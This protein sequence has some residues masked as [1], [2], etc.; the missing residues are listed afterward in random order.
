MAKKTN[1]PQQIPATNKGAQRP[2][3]GPA[4]VK[5]VATSGVEVTRG[6]SFLMTNLLLMAA[7]LIA[8]VAFL[9]PSLQNQFTNWDDP[10]YVL[11][12]PIIKDLSEGGLGRIF[13][14]SVMGNYHPLTML[15]YA[16]DYSSANL[17]PFHYHLQS[18]LFHLGTTLLV[19]V[20][21]LMLTKRPVAAVI[22]AL[23]FGIHPM[24]VE[25]VAW[26]A[27]RKDVVYG[28]FYMAACVA[29]LRYHK[30][31]AGNRILWYAGVLLLFVCSLLAKPVAVILPVTLLLI[32]LFQGRFAYLT[33]GTGENR[34]VLFRTLIEKIPFF[35]ISLGFG[36]RSVMYQKQFG[37]L[38]TQGEKFNFFERIGLGGYALVSYLWKA[39]VPVKLL[40]FYP[41]P[42]KEHG[43]LEAV[44]Y[45]YPVIAAVLLFAVFWFF[46]KNKGVVFGTLFFLTNIAL[47]LQFIPVGGAIIADRYS[48]IPYLGLFFVLGWVVSSLFEP[49][50]SK[51]AGRLALGAVVIW[52]LAIGVMA[53]ARCKV[54]YDAMSLWR[55]EIEVEPVRAP[56]AYN[57]LGFQYYN[58]FNASVDP[59]ERKLYYDSSYLLLSRAIELQADFVNPYIS[60]GELLRSNGQFPAA[61]QMYYAA[62]AKNSDYDLEANAYMGLAITYSILLN[63]DMQLRSADNA[64]QA[65]MIKNHDSAK[66]CYERTFGLK[67]YNPEAHSNFANFLDMTGEK[68]HAIKEY[69][70]SIQQNPDSYTP[71]LNRGRAYQRMQN[72]A[73]AFKDFNAAIAMKPEIGEIYYARSYCYFQE[74]KL[75]QALA[76]VD[77]ARSLG[78]RNIDEGYYQQL[79]R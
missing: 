7:V 15:T 39:V 1:N 55:D 47:L 43:A 3:A 50:G 48:Y 2:A 31:T 46:R 60:L 4:R 79:K 27:G 65:D 77:K 40:C 74:N 64:I 11:N 71:Y 41:Y 76:D 34:T 19:Y 61:K 13:R 42:L 25:S 72:C 56:N 57:N 29:Y 32:D 53:N 52:A 70:M 14:T 28:F 18:L 68:E 38:N 16:F 69:T 30:K 36:I 67:E 45:I 33:E 44:Y 23:L 20:F 75:P 58:K 9:F 24:H 17:E 73:A 5:P 59:N 22:T 10:G 8:T 78:F 26:I 51:Q 12:Q 63:Q 49:S 62:L 54:W 37:A 35:V 6:N 66:Y 21:V